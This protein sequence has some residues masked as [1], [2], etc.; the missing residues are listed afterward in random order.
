MSAFAQTHDQHAAEHKIQA[1]RLVHELA[2]PED[3]RKLEA[4]WREAALRPFPAE[5]NS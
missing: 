4:I 1:F 3:K 2:S 5:P